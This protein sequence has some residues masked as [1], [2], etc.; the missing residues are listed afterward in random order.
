MPMQ[1]PFEVKVPTT[2]LDLLVGNCSV[3]N[4]KKVLLKGNYTLCV[5][6]ASLMNDA[7]TSGFLDGKEF[8]NEQKATQSGQSSTQKITKNT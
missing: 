3:V 8:S 5:R 7:Y 2:A 6:A 4:G 1:K